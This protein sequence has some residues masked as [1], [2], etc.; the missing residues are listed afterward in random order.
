MMK[1]TD[2][3]QVCIYVKDNIPIPDEENIKAGKFPQHKRKSVEYYRTLY[4]GNSG[5]DEFHL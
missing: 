5:H 3:E 2:L 4:N 1:F